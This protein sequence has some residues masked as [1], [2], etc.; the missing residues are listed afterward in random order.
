V[1][2]WIASETG[3]KYITIPHVGLKDGILLDIV[4]DLSKNISLPLREQI[5]ES[6]LPVECK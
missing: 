5:W 6:T 4:A 2:H 1:L 3:V